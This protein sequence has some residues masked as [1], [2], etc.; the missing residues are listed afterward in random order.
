MSATRLPPL[1][2]REEE[3]AAMLAR[4]ERAGAGEGG[5]MLLAG[6][7]GIGKT[8]LLDELIGHA[9]ARQWRVLAG[10]AYQS[11][12]LPPYL[13]VVE[14]LR[15]CIRALTPEQRRAALG[16]GAGDLA[17]LAP[18]V[19]EEIGVAPADT[20]LSPEHERYR[21]FEAV[22]DFLR[23]LAVGATA[24]NP[25]HVVN[26][27]PGAAMAHDPPP[28]D[29]RRPSEATAR[30]G[31]LLIVDDLHWADTPTLLLF[32][33]I[34]RRVRD[35]P[36]LLVGTYR[37]VDLGR[38]HPLVGVLAE[39]RRE[40]LAERLLLAPLAETETRTLVEALAGRATP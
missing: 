7:P 30:G 17:R 35:A 39:L 19:F 36:V 33:H 14:A 20:A 18:S 12:G 16:R 8:R 4:L 29:E 23:T 34:A 32:Q 13:P 38:T 6:E 24:R 1:V 5:V 3:H 31:V 27:R 11:E 21:V 15:D 26:V 37:T 28:G 25:E 2:G 10:R 40:R 22:M 9:H